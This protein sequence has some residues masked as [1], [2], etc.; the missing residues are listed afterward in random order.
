M[1]EQKRESLSSWMKWLPIGL[2]SFIAKYG[3]IVV[4]NCS[5]DNDDGLQ[6]IESVDYWERK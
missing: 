5:Y 4:D 1:I 3:A 6:S 2:M